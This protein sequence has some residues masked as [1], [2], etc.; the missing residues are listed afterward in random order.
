MRKLLWMIV[1]AGAA[2]AGCKSSPA[3][4][5]PAAEAG[6]V[7]L[8][9]TERGKSGEAHTP[10]SASGEVLRAQYTGKH[11][12]GPKTSIVA[13]A[14]VEDEYGSIEDLFATLPSDQDMMEAFAELV[15]ETGEASAKYAEFRLPDEQRNVRV[16]AWLYAVKFESDKDFHVIIGSTRSKSTAEFM[17]VE[18]T[19]LPRPPTSDTDRLAEVR[20]QLRDILGRLP[21]GSRYHKLAT[22]IKVE[23][24]G[25]LFYDIDHPPGVVGPMDMRPRT[26]W[27]IHPI[28]DIHQ[29]WD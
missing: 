29:G 28:S 23:V 22:P 21:S 13:D 2:A 7:G 26:A 27:E 12:K 18:V 10:Q 16:R 1:F 19:G 11:R 3:P 14:P 9:I 4:R 20:V 17:N 6:T 24:E 5:G 15:E 8:V 25:S